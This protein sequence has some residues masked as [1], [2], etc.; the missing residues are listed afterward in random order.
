[1][2]MINTRP[3]VTTV[4]NAEKIASELQSGDNL[5]TYHVEV[6][7]IDLAQIAIYDEEGEFVGYWTS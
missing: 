5:W 2:A 3:L 7:F 6:E 4:E 1:M